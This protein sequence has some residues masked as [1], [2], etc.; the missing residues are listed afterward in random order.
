MKVLTSR[1]QFLATIGGAME[2]AALGIARPTPGLFSSWLEDQD[3]ERLRFGELDPLVDWL[4][5]SKPE[6]ALPVLVQRL[7]SGLELSDLV[8]ATALANARALGGRNYNGY[9][10]LMALMPSYEMARQRSGPLAA[11]PV[12]K[13]VYRNLQFIQDDDKGQVDTLVPLPAIEPAG[14][15]VERA[16]AGDLPGAEAVLARLAQKSAAEAFERVQELVRQDIDVHRVVLSWRAYDMARLAGSE[17]AASLLR[18]ELHFCHDAARGRADR[19]LGEPEVASVVPALL[20]SHG[21]LDK[22][23]GTRRA[24]DAAIEKLADTC[25]ASDRRGAAEAVALALAQGIDGADIARAL[26]LCST[27][28]VLHDRGQWRDTPG[29]PTGSV[30]GANYGVHASD[31]ANAWRHIAEVGSARHAHATLVAA[32][33]HTGEQGGEVA[34]EVFD[35]AAAPIVKRDPAELLALIAGAMRE[36]D[37]VTAGAA[38]RRYTSLGHGDAPL[39]EL[40][41]EAMVEQ[42]GALH[43]ETYFRTVQEEHAVARAA[44]QGLHLVALTRVAASGSGFPAPGLSEARDLLTG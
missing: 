27:R 2:L 43:A 36:R 25:F 41:L 6:E 16:R 17:N 31:A 15:L 11:L 32:A 13:V 37:M 18:Q 22:E 34:E 19:G 3:V 5:A 23:R 21:L 28:L 40:L 20:E 7:N 14:D 4:Q 8:A 33:Y 29:K 12:L 42:D 26:A 35:A 39:F 38:A 30:H 24:D 10:A 44:H 1:R 9:H